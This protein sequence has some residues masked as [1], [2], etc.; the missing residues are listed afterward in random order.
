MENYH[1]SMRSN[2]SQYITVFSVVLLFS[3]TVFSQ[4]SVTEI[5]SDFNGFWK[6]STAVVNPVRL[7]DSHNLLAFKVGSVIYSTGV[8]DATLTS[9][10]VIFTHQ[11][12]HAM[13]I[14]NI[15]SAGLIGVGAN[16]GGVPTGTVI[17]V[18]APLSQ[19]LID[20]KN[21]LD[22][23]TAVFN[24]SGTA[25]YTIPRIDP[26]TIGDG[27]PDILITQMGDPASAT[28]V[29]KFQFVSNSSIT[30]GSELSIILSTVK[31]IGSINWK[32]YDVL[33]T[34]VVKN[35]NIGNGPR[36]IRMIAYDF[37]DFGITLANY[38]DVTN[39]IHKLSGS[40]DQAFIA[41]N[42]KSLSVLPVELRDFSVEVNNNF[43]DI[44]WSTASEINN[45]RFEIERSKDGFNWEKIGEVKGN[46]T[47]NSNSY[48]SFKDNNPYRKVS[49]YRLKQ[50]DFDGTTKYYSDPE[51]VEINSSKIVIYPNPSTD[52]IQ[53]E[54]FKF[55]DS[56]I[57]IY[58]PN[59]VTYSSLLQTIEKGEDFL[60]L[61][62]SNLPNGV[63]L[64]KIDEQILKFVKQ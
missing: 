49:Y 51:S 7:N 13:P 61:D 27:I 10:N 53:I 29:D 64:L 41:Y 22:L 42:K 36:E 34:G 60:K 46:G 15:N 11:E 26:S 30:V 3:I 62:I 37:S 19:Y 14:S 58:S 17:P 5:Y 63:Y 25:R 23:G 21:G 9:N 54:G 8:G 43:V 45:D 20:G 44:N 4:K 40:S 48:Y 1:Y 52:F 47:I 24:I 18:S 6:S 50:I 35:S 33:N 57:A 56:N 31:P 12:F 55:E 39:F 59:G 38:Q 2:R 32:F 28:G 16:Y